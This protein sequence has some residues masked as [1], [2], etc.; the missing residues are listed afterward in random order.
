MP[1]INTDI[2][3]RT[4]RRGRVVNICALYSGGPGF[5][6][7]PGDRL[8]LGFCGFPQSLQANVRIILYLKLG[9]D[10][11]LSHSLQFVNSLI[12][13]TFYTV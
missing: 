2:L 8:P 11:C 7:R 12:A 13:L 1:Y 5:R 10:R 9:H 3:L 6:S 4:E